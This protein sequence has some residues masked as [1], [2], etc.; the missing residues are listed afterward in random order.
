[1]RSA[2]SPQALQRVMR[3][4]VDFIHAEGW[5]APP[6]LF[7]LVPTHLLAGQLADGGADEAEHPLTLIVQDNVPLTADDGPEELADYLGKIAWPPEVT[8]VVLAQEIMF[9]DAGRNADATGSSS[10]T[11]G[12]D[13]TPAAARPAR[14]FSGVLRSGAELTLIQ[15]RPTE[16]Q[17]A[18][19][20]LF[21]EDNIDL[22]GG[23]G[24]APEVIEALRA[25]LDAEYLPN[26]EL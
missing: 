15:V 23:P 14:L 22:R 3:E 12:S 10:E 13:T 6:T 24:V 11:E 2:D 25:G 18:A 7:G 5:D 16:E 8:G 20:G 4:A 19:G 1:M 21:A 17:L 9:R 26:A